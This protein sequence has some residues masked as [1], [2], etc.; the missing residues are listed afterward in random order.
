MTVL[1]LVVIIRGLLVGLDSSSTTGCR[2]T[3]THLQQ[4]PDL[5]PATP[6]IDFCI[7]TSLVRYNNWRLFFLSRR[8]GLFLVDRDC[9]S[10]LRFSLGTLRA[11]STHRSTRPRGPSL[12]ARGLGWADPSGYHPAIRLAVDHFDN[13]TSSE[14]CVQLTMTMESSRKHCHNFQHSGLLCLHYC[15]HG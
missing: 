2:L 3:T 9:S 8:H 13:T 12:I 15:S 6:R 14:Y 5:F 1:S 10:I 4:K 7:P 11:L